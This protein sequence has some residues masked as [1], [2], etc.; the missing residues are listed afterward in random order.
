MNS[1]MKRRLKIA[2][3]L[4]VVFLL[5]FVPRSGYFLVRNNPE[6]SDA[7]LVAAGAQNQA[8]YDRALELLRLGYAPVVLIDASADQNLYGHSYADLAQQF[9]PAL[10]GPLAD[11]I[12]V[13]PIAGDSTLLESKTAVACLQALH[14][15]RV[16]LVTSDYHTRRAF[17]IF[18][19][20]MPQY[21]WSVGAAP[22][23]YYF[24]P[25]WWT[26]RQWAKTNLL[27]WE[28]L[29]WWQVVERWTN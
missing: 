5:W 24:G 11:R 26:R 17:A 2:L 21:H 18:R 29:I 28:R 16:L 4:V 3:L 22:D 8:R 14:P 1:R 13:C 20:T 19:R 25:R 27:E 12:R 9:A 23:P 6:K 7:I 10:A 15:T